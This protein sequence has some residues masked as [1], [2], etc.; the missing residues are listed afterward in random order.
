MRVNVFIGDSISEKR[1]YEKHIKRLKEYQSVRIR[2]LR[3]F[4]RFGEFI[5]F[6]QFVKLRN[7]N[8]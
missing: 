2:T 5:S 4:V 8:Q 7:V 1:K 3:L 6:G